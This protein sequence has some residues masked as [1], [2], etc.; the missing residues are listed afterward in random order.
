MSFNNRDTLNNLTIRINCGPIRKKFVDYPAIYVRIKSNILVITTNISNLF[1]LDYK[2]PLIPIP[3]IFNVVS[4][5]NI[6]VNAKFIY[7]S[8][9]P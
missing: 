8:I 2:N 6:I 4:N 7:S 3:I 9:S 1:Q 5:I